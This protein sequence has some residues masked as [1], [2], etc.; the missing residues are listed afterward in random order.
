MSGQPELVLSTY[1]YFWTDQHTTAGTGVV[2]LLLLLD[3][4]THDS[5]DWCCQLT[6]TSGLTNTRQSG[7]VLSTYFYLWTDRHT[8][9][10]TG[11]VNL[12]LLLDRPTHDSRDWC[13][14][15]TSTSGQTNTRQPGLVLSTYFYLWTDQHTTAGTGVVNLLLLMVRPTHD[16]RDWCCQLTS[17]YGPTGTRLSRLVLSTY[18]YS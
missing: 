11:V 8:T 4:P 13:C 12:L 3:R 16:S 2:N 17:I 18:F 5:W 7:L 9:V 1:F 14:Q 6:S 10:G 15:L